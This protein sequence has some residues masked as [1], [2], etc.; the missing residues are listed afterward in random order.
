MKEQGHI[1]KLSQGLA[2]ILNSEIDFGNEVIETFSGWPKEETIL[3][4]LKKPFFKRY[5]KE[6]IEFREI[7]DP[8][9]WKDEYHDM[10]TDHIL[11]CKFG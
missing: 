11:A 10:V 5:L 7:N 2:E 9:Y 8:H 3:V 6:Q 1:E 4:I